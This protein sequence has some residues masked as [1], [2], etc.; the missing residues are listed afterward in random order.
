[1]IITV[2][3][4]PEPLKMLGV[5]EL[6]LPATGDALGDDVEE[7]T[8]LDDR[9]MA[10]AAAE[11]FLTPFMPEDLRDLLDGAAANFTMAVRE[12]SSEFHQVNSLYSQR[13]PK[14]LNE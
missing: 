1:M 2:C 7:R 3:Q 12:S 5:A 13:G 4:I 14:N 6:T 9:T 8:R 11:V 10:L